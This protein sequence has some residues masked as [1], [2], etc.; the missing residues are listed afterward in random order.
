[1]PSAKEIREET[2]TNLNDLSISRKT[3]MERIYPSPPNSPPQG[4]QSTSK[5]QRQI[6]DEFRT[7][8]TTSSGLIT[9]PATPEKEP[10]SNDKG[11]E[12]VEDKLEISSSIL[13]SL[14]GLNEW[15]CG[16][17]TQQ[18]RPCRR[19]IPESNKDDV[20]SQV[21]N[22]V[23]FTQSSTELEL[24]LRKLVMLVH[25]WQHDHGYPLEDRIEAWIAVFP[26]GSDN[27]TSA[28]SVE[29][30]VRKVLGRLSVQCIGITSKR[31]R[32]KWGIG[33]QKVQNCIKTI[34][35]IVT[36]EVYLNDDHLEDL[37]KVLETNMFCHIHI[38]KQTLK[39][40]EGWKSSIIAIRKKAASEV[41][42]STQSSKQEEC[43]SPSETA[44]A[45]ERKSLS[46]EK[47]NDTVSTYRSLPTPRNS[48]SISVDP[49]TYWPKAYDATPFDIIAKNN[50]T[51]DYAAGYELVRRELLRPLDSKDQDK[52]YIYLYE[53]EGNSGFVKL[54]YTS[55]STE[56]RHKEWSFD[57]NRDPK[58][59]YPKALN[60][61]GMVLNARRVEALCHAELDHRRIR[62]YCKG[63]LKQ[64]IEWFEI[65]AE[66]A[67]AVIEK[68]SKWM[69]TDPYQS[70]LRSG[71]KLLKDEESRRTED[72]DQFMKEISATVLSKAASMLHFEKEASESQVLVTSSNRS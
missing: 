67:I 21:Q 9:P 7:S 19:P 72:I 22:M 4:K 44:N 32:C 24:K 68:W 34:D 6:E 63:C 64:H 71:L 11:K 30:Q 37:L 42:Q 20:K 40:V 61:D 60:I 25:C 51:A 33:G 17:L 70:E 50:R 47:N 55:R 48:R 1:M 45:E 69:S 52:G 59:L 15:R 2:P 18:G 16:C 38:N 8:G 23:T 57:C 36:P 66:E 54:G 12:A 56:K 3:V 62:I 46:S 49:V 35:K 26:V 39:S 53:V 58:V 41:I 31:E 10:I 43:R 29:K 5:A 13:N 65:S 28:I 27:T 14:L